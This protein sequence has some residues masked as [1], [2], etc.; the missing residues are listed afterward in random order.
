[1][2]SDGAMIWYI[3]PSGLEHYPFAPFHVTAK[4]PFLLSYDPQD[5][6]KLM[7]GTWLGSSSD[8]EQ[9]EQRPLEGDNP[10][11][12]ITS[13]ERWVFVH[14]EYDFIELRISDD[15]GERFTAVRVQYPR[16][17]EGRAKTS[18][19]GYVAGKQ[20]FLL[21]VREFSVSETTQAQPS[22]V[23]VIRVD[24]AGHAS[25][26][27]I[28]YEHVH[29]ANNVFACATPNGAFATIGNHLVLHVDDAPTIV[30][31]FEPARTRTLACQG[32]RAFALVHDPSV[33]LQRYVCSDQDCGDPALL[34][35]LDS[36]SSLRS[37]AGGVRAVFL[38]GKGD[39]DL[40]VVDE[41]LGGPLERIERL[42]R[43][44]QIENGGLDGADLPF[45]ADGRPHAASVRA[46]EFS[47]ASPRAAAND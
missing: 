31:D 33:G 16:Q 15:A 29:R 20:L 34:T 13:P 5:Q 21:V 14:D 28:D 24:E 39:V 22:L 46:H 2:K 18:Q 7:L 25:T 47:M 42:V 10:S 40:Y 3:P 4:Q 19:W 26:S 17:F 30:H 36:S 6:S 23:F 35:T 32:E 8:P 12:V 45:M 41:P 27:S 9:F 11:I 38:T 37:T 1:V 43:D 44:D